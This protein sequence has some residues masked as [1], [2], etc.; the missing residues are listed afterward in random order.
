MKSVMN[1]LSDRRGAGNRRGATLVEVLMSLLVISLG[2]TSVFT[3]FPL[4]VVRSLK[5]TVRTNAALV[6]HNAQEIVRSGC[7]RSGNLPVLVDP[8]SSL[9][10]GTFIVDPY[11]WS[12]F[13]DSPAAN[14]FGP[15]GVPRIHGFEWFP[16]TPPTPEQLDELY[17]SRDSWVTLVEA[18]A[19]SVT[20]TTVTFPND[21]DLQNV[22]ASSR[23]VVYNS[24]RTASVSRKVGTASGRVV[25]I[26]STEP[27]FPASIT[28][29]P[30]EARIETFERRYTWLLSVTQDDRGA[31]RIQ[32]VV[33]FRRAFDEASETPYDIVD[34]NPNDPR[35]V[36]IDISGGSPDVS[37]GDI[38]FG[39]YGSDS[40]PPPP[41]ANRTMG[42]WYRV[43]SVNQSNG[44]ILLDRTWEGP[45]ESDGDNTTRDANLI[46]PTGAV[47]V[48]DL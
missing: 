7:F 12:A 21:V 43:L 35:R 19:D 18:P 28:S 48:F 37:P 16:G 36:T 27:N 32:C 8:P 2:V 1:I 5:A 15:N 11:G 31:Q 17:S 30:G 22:G 44:E 13:K 40:V 47:E 42:V 46:F 39:A 29:D 26:D 25:T 23:I 4:T 24:S 14:R 6:A 9:T 3:L 34:V 41:A 38:V 45:L 10:A 20:G 33:F